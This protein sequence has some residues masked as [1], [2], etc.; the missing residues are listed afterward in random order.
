MSISFIR[1]VGSAVKSEWKDEDFKHAQELHDALHAQERNDEWWPFFAGAP[2]SR[3]R[4]PVPP[5][6]PRAAPPPPP[7]ARRAT[8]CGNCKGYA[9]DPKFCLPGM[10]ACGCVVA[11]E[12]EMQSIKGGGA[13]ESRVALRERLTNM[14]AEKLTAALAL[15]SDRPRVPVKGG[16]DKAQLSY[17]HDRPRKP[18]TP[19]RA[20]KVPSP[21]ARARARRA[22]RR[23]PELLSARPS[24]SRAGAGDVDRDEDAPPHAPRQGGARARVSEKRGARRG[25]AHRGG[26]RRAQAPCRRAGAHGRR[27]SPLLPGGAR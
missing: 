14:L 26:G 27:A 13:A 1:E 23:R 15:L 11:M 17:L 4:S 5:P 10:G 16:L 25:A 6:P 7:P 9:F 22:S 19:L 12:M 3:A 20:R 18:A 2:P 24:R 8:G 21:G